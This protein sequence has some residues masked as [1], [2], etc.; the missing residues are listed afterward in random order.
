MTLSQVVPVS[1][2]AGPRRDTGGA[3]TPSRITPKV[4]VL[5]ILGALAGCM[6][7]PPIVVPDPHFVL[8][9]A[10]QAGGVWHYPRE[11]Y[12]LYETGLAQATEAGHPSLTS[13]GERYDPTAMAAA[14]PTLQLP[15]IARVS[16]M[17]TGRSVLVRVNDRGTGNPGRLIEMTP[18]VAALLGVPADGVARVQV[19][20]LAAESHAADE[21]MSGAPRLALEPAP[22]D[23]VEVSELP[24]LPG[25]R[26]GQGHALAGPRA[27]EAEVATA[28]LPLR[29]PE[30]VT[31]GTPNPGRLWVR[32]GSFEEYQYAAI[33][34]AR[35]IG[36]R[37]RVERVIEGR[38]P[39]FRVE[40]GPF[41]D[42]RQ[43]DAALDQALAAG[44]PDARI[45][46][47]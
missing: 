9:P 10:Y 43:A 38:A 18:R 46:V 4:A 35:V 47:E 14:H 20:V 41:D 37:P 30:A 40:S 7:R 29:L 34:H 22:R 16:N 11:N 8:G 5:L 21:A 17:E 39:L 32:F 23:A 12:D 31:Q 24:P 6:P 3:A 28:M 44:I 36:L 13:D 1:A 15:A 2:T 25:S 26:Q 27:A 33:L 42:V 45:V 19:Q